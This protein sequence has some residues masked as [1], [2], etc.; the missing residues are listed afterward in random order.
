[1]PNLNMLSSS[2]SGQ[3]LRIYAPTN[4]GDEITFKNYV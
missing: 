2:E 3:I 4:Q 1:M